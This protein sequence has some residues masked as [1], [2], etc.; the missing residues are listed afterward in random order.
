M[1]PLRM[2]MWMLFLTGIAYPLCVTLI[3]YV[4]MRH[5]AQGSLLTFEG[6]VIGSSLIAQKF[7]SSQYF[8]PRPSAIDYQPLPSGGS[9]LGPTSR[10]LK[11]EVEMRRSRYTSK[12]V[13]SEL[14]FASA[15]GIDPHISPEAAY[16][17]SS[18]VANARHI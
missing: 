11:K 5:K 4:A 2:F 3:S 12:Q 6:R 7:E 8:W 16:F 9:N 18:R 17:Q 1:K 13:P 15:S 14:L 10:E